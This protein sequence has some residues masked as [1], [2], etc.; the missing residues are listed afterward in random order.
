MVDATESKGSA[1]A[2][3]PALSWL[4]FVLMIGMAAI[5]AK[6]AGPSER[7]TALPF[8]IT[9]LAV[10]PPLMWLLRLVFPF[11][12]FRWAPAVFGLVAF[13]ASPAI[14]ASLPPEALGISTEASRA[15][16]RTPGSSAPVDRDTSKT[17]GI[18][19]FAM[20]MLSSRLVDPGSA[21]LS[22]VIVFNNHRP[23][24]RI[25]GFVNSKNRMGG[26]SGREQFIISDRGVFIG[27]AEAPAAK[28]FAECKGTT[29][30]IV[31]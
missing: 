19:G 23:D 16:E 11:F 30:A 3:F 18:K 9:A 12:R 5:T 27:E 2:E 21:K 25:C 13:L 14:L 6:V 8:L 29:T 17:D 24:M 15:P 28:V 4:A 1:R 31:R 10:F 22:D 7:F 20:H 26:Y